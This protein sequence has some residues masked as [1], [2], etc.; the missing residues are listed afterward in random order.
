MLDRI[1]EHAADNPAVVDMSLGGMVAA[2]WGR[3]HPECPAVIDIQ[4]R[5]VATLVEGFLDNR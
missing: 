5:T 1:E 3:R 2:L 4:P